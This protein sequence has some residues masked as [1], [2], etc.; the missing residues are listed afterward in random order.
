MD[1]YVI[2]TKNLSKK[3]EGRAVVDGLNLHVPA[4]KIYALLGRNGAGKTTTMKMLLNLVRPTDGSLFLFGETSADFDRKN[5]N[6]IGSLIETPAF[7]ENLTAR[8]NLE[9]LAR[10][11]GRHR[12][13]TIEHALMA[14]HLDREHKKR[15][16]EYSLGMKQR[17]GLAA[18]IMHEPE[19]LILDEPMNGLDPVGIHEARSCLLQLCR[20]KGTT[21]F[22]SSH[23][24]SEIEQLAEV[25]G[26]IDK[27]RLL[28]ETGLQELYTRSRKYV[29]F[30]LSDVKKAAL[31]L[32][33]RFGIWDYAVTGNGTLRLYEQLSRRAEINSGLI[34]EGLAVSGISVGA[35]KLEDYFTQL[36]GGEGIG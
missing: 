12:K 27:G 7:Y 30:E 9:I 36:V 2:E 18:A 3:Y 35:G 20:E 1:Q 29:E 15:F 26:V 5:Y 6:R 10:L 34:E 8:E 24:L 25:I 33:R 13:D 31:V 19:L 32:E 17:L 23:I 14:F 11:R 16:C 28:E 22:L 21:I 4:G